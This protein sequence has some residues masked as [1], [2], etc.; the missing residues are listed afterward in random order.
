MEKRKPICKVNIKKYEGSEFLPYLQPAT[1]SLMLAQ[2]VRNKELCITYCSSRS[3]RISIFFMLSLFPW[4]NVKNTKWNF[5][6]EERNFEFRNAESFII[7]SKHPCSLLQRKM[8]SLSP[9]AICSTN[10]LEKILQ[11]KKIE[12]K[13]VSDLQ[14]VQKR[15]TRGELLPYGEVVDA[16]KK[17]KAA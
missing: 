9:K 10:I 8:L 16:R 1:G 5:H 4:G 7:D 11:E 3:H 15:E 12:R 17:N 14:D 13:L 2:D 6:T